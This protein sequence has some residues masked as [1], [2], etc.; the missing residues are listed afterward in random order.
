MAATA[1][2]HFLIRLLVLIKCSAQLFALAL[3]RASLVVSVEI[4]V[5]L[6][7]KRTLSR[8]GP[9]LAVDLG[10]DLQDDCLVKLVLLHVLPLDR[11]VDS[12]IIAI[13][14]VGMVWLKNYL[15]ERL[16][17]DSSV[18]HGLIFR[19]LLVGPSNS[20]LLLGIE[21]PTGLIL[22]IWFPTGLILGIWIPT[23]LLLDI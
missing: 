23:G 22:G 5:P 12:F 16:H 6:I 1:G 7:T 3:I 10:A 18:L 2:H 19:L 21:S 17:K 8:V 20:W 14:V 13:K 15:C 11:I 4:K 9:S